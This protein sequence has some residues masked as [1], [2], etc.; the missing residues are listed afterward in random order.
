MI[1]RNR[2]P[3]GIK[4]ISRRRRVK[5]VEYISSYFGYRIQ[6]PAKNRMAVRIRRAE[7]GIASSEKV[8]MVFQCTGRAV[9]SGGKNIE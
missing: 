5:R 7:S 3:K 8:R 6:F 4:R 2:K 1:P 9:G